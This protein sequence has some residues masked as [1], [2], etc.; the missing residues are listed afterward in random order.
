MELP[1]FPDCHQLAMCL[2]GAAGLPH[3]FVFV[4]ALGGPP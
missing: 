4:A 3:C 2:F 1:V